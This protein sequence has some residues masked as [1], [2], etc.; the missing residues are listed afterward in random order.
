MAPI[1][2]VLDTETLSSLRTLATPDQPDFL[3]QLF[4][5]FLESAP[6]RVRTIQAAMRS[7]D[8][9]TAAKEAHI[10]KSSSANIGATELSQISQRL[11]KAAR[12]SDSNGAAFEANKLQNA[13]DLV[14]SEI[15][16]LP[17]MNPLK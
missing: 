13:L 6:E 12:S 2:T 4:T 3:K 9:A 17:E 16:T 11:E 14:L 15:A 8:L 5:L 7:G 10:L 1:S